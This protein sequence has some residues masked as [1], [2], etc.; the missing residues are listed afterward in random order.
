MSQIE[1]KNTQIIVQLGGVEILQTLSI[2]CFL[3]NGASRKIG[4]EIS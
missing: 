3:S 2:S 4:F 1:E